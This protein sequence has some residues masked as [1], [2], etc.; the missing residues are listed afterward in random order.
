MSEPDALIDSNIFVY[1]W[2]SLERNKHDIALELFEKVWSREI[3]Y[4]VSVQNLAEFSSVLLTKGERKENPDEI[5]AFIQIIHE[6]SHWQVLT[7]DAGIMIRAL[8]ITKE[9]GLH[10]WDSLLVATMEKNGIRRI[11]TE[12]I[13]LKK[14]PWIEVINPFQ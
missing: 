8:N 13:H 5:S 6:F 2:V 10:F 4:A 14:I 7:Y 1:A 12:D 11:I 9:Y 3:I